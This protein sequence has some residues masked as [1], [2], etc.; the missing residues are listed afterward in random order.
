MLC[1]TYSHLHCVFFFSAVHK[2]NSEAWFNGI[3]I[4]YTLS[5][6][7]FKGTGINEQL[8]K[9]GVFVTITTFLTLLIEI[10]YPFLIWFK[11]TRYFVM[12]PT[13]LMHLGIYIFMMIYDFQ[14]V[15]IMIQGF[16]FLIRFSLD[17]IT[18]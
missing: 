15:F 7:R 6:E 3:A 8:A 14:I 5:I 13:I 12:I 16:L 9:N 4:Y 11:Q 1:N 2:I 18:G 17:I 10:A